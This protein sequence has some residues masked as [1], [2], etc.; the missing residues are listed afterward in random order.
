MGHTMLQAP[1][2]KSEKG[3]SARLLLQ[4]FLHVPQ[5]R[6]ATENK[7]IDKAFTKSLE[8]AALSNG[9]EY[10]MSQLYIWYSFS[11]SSKYFS[12]YFANSVDVQLAPVHV[13]TS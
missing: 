5:M 4:A 13:G 10:E 11:K 3:H 7:I 1:H 9:S 2:R 6:I 8:D 12:L